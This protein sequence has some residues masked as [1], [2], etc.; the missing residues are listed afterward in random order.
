MTVLLAVHGVDGTE[1]CGASCYTAQGP[2]C[3]C[4]VCGGVNHGVGVEQATRN[5]ARFAHRWLARY[6]ARR[7]DDHGH[8][9]LPLPLWDT[10]K[11]EPTA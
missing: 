9:Q 7:A 11:L 10:E 4:G 1:A 3:K 8:A 5:T 2:V 6:A